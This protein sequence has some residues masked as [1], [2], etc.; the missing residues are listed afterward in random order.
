MAVSMLTDTMGT[1]FKVL[2]ATSKAHRL[3]ALPGF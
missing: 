1:R 2:G 3:A